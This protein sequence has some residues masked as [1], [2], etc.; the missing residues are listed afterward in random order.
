MPGKHTACTDCGDSIYNVPEAH[1]DLPHTHKRCVTYEQLSLLP[2][3]YTHG[4][5][6]DCE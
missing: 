2:L 1:C 6:P 4:Q 5:E 3:E